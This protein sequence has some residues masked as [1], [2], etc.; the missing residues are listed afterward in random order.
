MKYT[1]TIL[2]L[3]SAI[4]FALAA[5]SNILANELEEVVITATRMQSADPTTHL[6]KIDSKAL[7]EQLIVTTDT[8]SILSNKLPAFAPSRQ[9]L[10]SRGETLRGREPL[11]MVDGVPQSNPLRDGDRTSQTIAPLALESIEVIHAANSIHGVGASGGTIN[12]VTRTPEEGIK[13]TVQFGLRGQ[14]ETESLGGNASY[15]IEASDGTSDVILVANTTAEGYYYDAD[16]DIVGSDTVQGDSQDSDANGLFVKVGHNLSD[17]HRLSL[18]YN[19]YQQENN[20]GLMPIKAGTAGNDTDKTISEERSQSWTPATTEIEMF[21]LAYEGQLTDQTSMQ[22]NGY[23]QTFSAIFGGGCWADFYDPAYDPNTNVNSGTVAC[24]TGSA[25]ETYFW[26]QSRNKSDKQG[27]K[28]SFITEFDSFDLGYGF[29]YGTDTTEQDMVQTPRA[30]VPESEYQSMGAYLQ[31]NWELTESITLSGGVRQE[32][33][34]LTVNDYH[35]LYG[36]GDTDIAGGTVDYS[37]TLFNSGASWDLSDALTLRASYSQGYAMPDVGRA[38]RSPATG[39]TTVG[40]FLT[41]QPVITDNYEAGFDYQLDRLELHV[42]AYQSTSDFGN[43]MTWVD[44]ANFGGHYELRRQPVEYNGIEMNLSYELSDRD[45]IGFGYALNRGYEDVED[46]QSGQTKQRDLTGINSGLDRM[47]VSWERDWNPTWASRIQASYA[48]DRNYHNENDDVFARFDGYLLV[49]AII[50]QQLSLGS[51][52][53]GI[54]NLLNEDYLSYYSQ[55]E[56]PTS[57]SQQFAGIGRTW[58]IGY[59]VSF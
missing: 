32:E 26:D 56:K 39:A 6:S 14:E 29:D 16:G 53:Y 28:L 48:F 49:D 24:G 15:S 40:D 54:S 3:T 38:L 46:A 57:T 13:H 7:S 37:E 58:S 59:Q 8:S 42:T 44:D 51:L 52:S 25:N 22:A 4:A 47:L 23:Y 20:G 36:Y 19:Y 33:G 41:L 27:I 21:N 45:L 10:S 35:T 30:W 1:N 18:S 34:E 43:T 17:D 31:V 2:P 5:N 9:K 50:T 12:L 55:T 11:Y